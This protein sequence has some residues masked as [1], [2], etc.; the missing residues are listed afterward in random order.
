M[1]GSFSSLPGGKHV[2]IGDRFDQGHTQAVGE[3]GPGVA[4]IADFAATVFFDGKLYHADGL[5]SDGKLTFDSQDGCAL[6][7]SGD[8]SVQILFSGDV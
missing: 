3:I 8:A 6:K 5:G 1:L 4:M 7:A 2:R